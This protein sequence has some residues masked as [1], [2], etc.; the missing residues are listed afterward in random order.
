[1]KAQELFCTAGQWFTL[2]QAEKYFRDKVSALNYEILMDHITVPELAKHILGFLEQD[3]DLIFF[4]E[5]GDYRVN[6]NLGNPR[7]SN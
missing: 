3:G 5:D 6:H 7:F 4:T 2:D 1:M